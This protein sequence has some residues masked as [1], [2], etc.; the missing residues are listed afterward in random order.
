MRLLGVRVAILALGIIV[1]GYGANVDDPTIRWIG[2]ALL[3][4][5]LILR[6]FRRRPAENRVMPPGE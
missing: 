4:L 1:W 2:I 6:F 5:S 3:A